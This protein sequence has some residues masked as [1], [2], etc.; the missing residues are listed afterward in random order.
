MKEGRQGAA[1]SGRLVAVF[2]GAHKG[3]GKEPVESGQLVAGVGL[4]GDS[5]AGIDP[6]RQVSL[7]ANETLLAL[8]SEGFTVEAGDLSANLITVDLSLDDLVI[9][10][11][12]RI[13][14]AEIE[15][16][17][18]RKPCASL[19]KLD[20]RLPKRLYQRCGWLGCVVKSGIIRPGAKIE[21]LSA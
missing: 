4:V 12:L 14:E 17:E 19:T 10:V 16:S 7:F 11:R 21:I 8:H 6:R 3:E 9:G 20:R 1:A 13:G 2:S 5:H 15:L 18:M